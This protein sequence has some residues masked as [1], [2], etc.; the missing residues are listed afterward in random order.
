MRERDVA[1]VD[2]PVMSTQKDL[3]HVRLDLFLRQAGSISTML[4]ELQREKQRLKA[5]EK[6]RGM[7]THNVTL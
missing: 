5:K 1:K 6:A 3:G 7:R 2:L 4:F